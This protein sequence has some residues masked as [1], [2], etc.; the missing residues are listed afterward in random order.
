MTFLGAVLF[1][2]VGAFLLWLAFDPGAVM[3][4]IDRYTGK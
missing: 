1:L 3:E 4:I 2:G